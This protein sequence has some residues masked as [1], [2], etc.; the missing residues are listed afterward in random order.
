[1]RQLVPSD[2]LPTAAAIR[3]GT[4]LLQFDRDFEVLARHRELAIYDG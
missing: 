3:E 4:P 2:P 1:M